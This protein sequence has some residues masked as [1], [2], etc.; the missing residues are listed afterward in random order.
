MPCILVNFMGGDLVGAPARV[1]GNFVPLNPVRQGVRGAFQVDQPPT[2]GGRVGRAQEG[3]RDGRSCQPYHAP[4][5]RRNRSALA[6]KAV[7]SLR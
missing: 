5:P 2:L 7:G 3:V 1:I 4:H 6:G